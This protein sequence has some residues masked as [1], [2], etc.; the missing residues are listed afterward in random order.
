MGQG[1]VVMGQGRAGQGRM[2]RLSSGDGRNS[3]GR[4]VRER[5]H[6][7]AILERKQDLALKP[8]LDQ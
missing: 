2:G 8:E 3:V 1:K 5:T 6:G 7:P 4:A